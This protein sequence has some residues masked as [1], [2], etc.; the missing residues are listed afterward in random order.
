MRILLLFLFF[1]PIIYF[2]SYTIIKKFFPKNFS[3]EYYVLANRKVHWIDFAFSTIATI[4]GASST[5]GLLGQ[6]Y[7]YGLKGLWWI[8]A[9]VPWILLGIFLNIYKIARETNALTLP[10][11]IKN[12]S[13]TFSA[14]IV[15]IIIASSWIAVISAQIIALRKIINFLNYNEVI[16]ILFLISI[17]AYTSIYGQEGVIKTDKPQLIIMFISLLIVAIDLVLQKKLPNPNINIFDLTPP[18]INYIIFAGPLYLIGPDIFSRLLSLNSSKDVNKGFA[19]VILGI[20]IFSGLLGL[21]GSY[22]HTFGKTGID[23]ETIIFSFFSSSPI[24]LYLMCAFFILAIAS[25]LDTLLITTTSIITNDIL[26]LKNSVLLAISAF[27][28]TTL[29][30]VLSIT[31]KSIIDMLFIGY[32]I[33]A[34]T[35][36]IPLSVALWLWDKKKEVPHW[37][38]SSS[39]ITGGTLTLI[40]I[41]IKNDILTLTAM[42]VSIFLSVTAIT[43]TSIK[44]AIKR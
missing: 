21:L 27:I 28:I 43:I 25:S 41:I 32:K 29:A 8:L 35:V 5:L 36:P 15:A 44:N 4:F 22:V 13:D 39:V 10:D 30:Y 37:L 9:S 16:L 24:L 31:G 7:T 17:L 23:K 12:I 18:A 38:I 3:K 34:T 33:F 20:L 1:L 14:K 42:L 26:P 40:S 11:V 6:I 19:F 2:F